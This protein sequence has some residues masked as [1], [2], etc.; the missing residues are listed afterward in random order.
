MELQ[1]QNTNANCELT[2]NFSKFDLQNYGSNWVWRA[3]EAL[4]TSKTFDPSATAIA[5]RLNVSIEASVNALEGLERLGFIVRDGKT[6]IKPDNLTLVDAKTTSKAELLH[7]HAHLAPQIVGMLDEDSIF[8]TQISLG[9]LRIAKKHAHK[10][11]EFM[12]AV[13]A[14]GSQEQNPELIA[15]EI[16][17]AQIGKK[18]D[19]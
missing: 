7:A 15:I 19:L 9:S 13:D 4:V 3:V 12:D 2:T 5:N 6:F 17:I 14:D 18:G 11:I 8:S 1:I 10:L 16:S